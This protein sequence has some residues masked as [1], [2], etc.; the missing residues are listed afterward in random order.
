VELTSTPTPT[1][2]ETQI[3]YYYYFL[4]DCEQT[5]NKIG[6]SLTSG[7]TEII[8]SL[9]NGVCYEIVGYEF[10]PEFDYD[11][12]DLRVVLDCRD[13]ACSTPTPTPTSTVETTPTPTPTPIIPDNDFT[14]VIIPNNDLSYTLIPS[15][16]LVYLLIPN[17]DLT[18]TLIPT[19]DLTHTLIPGNDLLYTLVPDGDLTYVLLPDND[20]NPIEIPNNDINYSLI[21]NNDLSYTLIPNNDLE[22]SVLRP[23][24]VF[25]GQ[26]KL[27]E[28]SVEGTCNC[29]EWECPRFYVTGDGPTFCESNNFV[30]NGDGFGFSGWGT[31]SYDGYYKT[32]NLNGTNVATYRTDCGTCPSINPTCD[33]TYNIVPFDMTCDIT[34][35]I[36]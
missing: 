36:I 27:G 7:L 1:P 20:L 35:N 25:Y 5:H 16:D 31:I 6:R 26:I 21:P 22:Y 11:L 23:P 34:Y 3:T 14:Y 19:N 13:V 24:A 33:I 29:P 15:N 2:T 17:D 10:G 8:Y 12:D 28:D 32:V 9:G 30:T 18:F 4:R